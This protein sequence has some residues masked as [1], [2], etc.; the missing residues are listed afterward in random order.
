ML[1]RGKGGVGHKIS[2]CVSTRRALG[3]LLGSRSLRFKGFLG[4]LGCLRMFLGARMR[5][6]L[7]NRGHQLNS[8]RRIRYHVLNCISGTLLPAPLGPQ[9]TNIIRA[10]GVATF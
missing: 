9:M 3:Q 4:S 2:G 5:N 7:P 1:R 10:F 8:E 6:R